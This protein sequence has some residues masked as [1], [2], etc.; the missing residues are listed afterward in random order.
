MM[1][2]L[3]LAEYNAEGK[4]ERFLE[5]G[6]GFLFGGNYI[7]LDPLPELG[8]ELFADDIYRKDPKD[9]LKRFDG[10]F[11]GRTYGDGRFVLVESKMIDRYDKKIMMSQDDIFFYDKYIQKAVAFINFDDWLEIEKEAASN[12]NFKIL[13][14]LHE[15]PELYEKIK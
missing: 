1:I 15:N 9:P 13:G 12:P 6:E 5:L 4:F 3:K 11:D 8:E 7:Y 14:N 10:L 2:N